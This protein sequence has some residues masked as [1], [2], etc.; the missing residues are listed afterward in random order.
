[1]AATVWIAWNTAALWALALLVFV[2]ATRGTTTR[3]VVTA[4]AAA[5]ETALVLVLYAIWR[6]VHR[7]T[8]RQVHGAEDHGRWVWR[9]PRAPPTP[10]GGRAPPPPR[11]P[12]PAGGG[13]PPPFPPPPPPAG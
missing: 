13:P 10:R 8:I 11:P 2:A 6:F 4:R 3:W 1:M 5:R 7:L 12:P 9:V